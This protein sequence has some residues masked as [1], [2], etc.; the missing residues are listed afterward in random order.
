MRH[1]TS[2]YLA[3]LSYIH[4]CLTE[5]SDAHKLSFSLNHRFVCNLI[6]ICEVIPVSSSC[7]VLLSCVM[8]HNCDG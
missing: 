7:S 2:A 6:A 1:H 8:L 5:C 4:K 3:L